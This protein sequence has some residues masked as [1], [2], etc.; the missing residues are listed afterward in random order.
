MDGIVE[1]YTTVD[2]SGNYRLN[3]YWVVG[4]H[5]TNLFDSTHW[6]TF[7]GSLPPRRALA[8]VTFNW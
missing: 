8:H 6:E 5:V 3:R 2:L 1:A 7:G 4:A